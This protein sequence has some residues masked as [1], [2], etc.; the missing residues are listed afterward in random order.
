MQRYFIDNRIS[1][2]REIHRY[3]RWR[4]EK[5]C[6]GRTKKES[7]FQLSPLATHLVQTKQTHPVM[8][9]FRGSDQ[10]AGKFKLELEEEMK[11]K[12]Y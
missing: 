8:K 3:A 5:K 11:V 12:R 2:R 6:E 1:R 9:Q 7:S 4:E 10:K